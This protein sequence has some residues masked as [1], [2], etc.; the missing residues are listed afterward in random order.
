MYKVLEVSPTAK[1]SPGIS[2]EPGINS[3]GRVHY[4]PQVGYHNNNPQR[5]VCHL[6]K[7]KTILTKSSSMWL[8]SFLKWHW[9]TLLHAE[10][11]IFIFSYNNLDFAWFQLVIII[12]TLHYCIC[13]HQHTVPSLVGFRL[14][15][16]WYYVGITLV[17][18]ALDS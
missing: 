1:C 6:K 2:K 14:M 18:L 13:I 9:T 3:H 17:M 15:L 11:I 10:I 16:C 8:S 5:L 7:K 4:R 12:I